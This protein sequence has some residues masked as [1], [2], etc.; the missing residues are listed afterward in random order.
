MY[1]KLGSI[2]YVSSGHKRGEGG[3]GPN[4]NGRPLYIEIVMYL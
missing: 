2:I 3:T 4:N 1:R